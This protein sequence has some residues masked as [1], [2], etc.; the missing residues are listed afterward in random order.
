MVGLM[1]VRVGVQIKQSFGFDNISNKMHH[2][3]N[4]MDK[5]FLRLIL[6]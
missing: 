2:K 3:Q 5:Y 4:R 6:S 1:N